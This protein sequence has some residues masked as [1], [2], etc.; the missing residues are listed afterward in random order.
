MNFDRLSA[1]SIKTYYQCPLQF[2]FKYSLRL[3]ETEAPHPLTLMGSA[4]HLMFEKATLAYLTGQGSTNPL[5]YKSQACQEFKVAIDLYGL[6]DSLAKNAVDWGYFRNMTR[7]VGCEIEFDFNLADG[8]PVKGFIDRLD[9][10][11]NT[12][13]IIDL[14]TQQ[15]QFEQDELNDNWQ[16]KIYNIATRKKYPQVTADLDVSFWVV[17]H[18]VQKVKLSADNAFRDEAKMLDVAQEIRACSNPEPK[19]TALCKWCSWK[20]QCPMGNA[21]IKARLNKKMKGLVVYK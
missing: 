11:D 7:T 21:G 18:H 2:H 10:W 1:S 17:R 4:L 9:L 14:K 5:D 19:P 12:A 6:L 8:T 13:D 15:K 16:A 3:P 20:G